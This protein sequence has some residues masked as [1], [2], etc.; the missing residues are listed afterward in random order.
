MK[1]LLFTIQAYIGR[2]FFGGACTGCGAIGPAICSSCLAT[3]PLS[4]T[5]EHQGIYGLYN[6]GHPL[7]SHAIWNLKYSHRGQEAKLL[8]QKAQEL[9]A[10]IISDELQSTT[11][12]KIVFVPIPQYKKKTQ[13]RGFNQSDLIAN[14]FTKDVPLAQ[15]QELLE[16]YKETLPQSHISSKDAR[17]KNIHDTMKVR[18]E[19]N[20]KQIYVVVD[21]VTTTGATF[22]EAIRALKSAGAKHIICIA[23]AH[24]Y[25]RR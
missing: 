25:K 22:L 16:K 8:S 4:S 23:L 6:Y 21:D 20:P 17:M 15:V 1:K 10:E 7:V 11:P 24:G 13:S 3:I 5:T 19:I 9:I 2:L 18:G 12:E 14:W